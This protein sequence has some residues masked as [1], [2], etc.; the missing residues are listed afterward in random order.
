MIDVTEHYDIKFGN[1]E[2]F[3]SLIMGIMFSNHYRH[4]KSEDYVY[5]LSEYESDWRIYWYI[6]SCHIL[7]HSLSTFVQHITIYENSYTHIYWTINQTCIIRNT[8]LHDINNGLWDPWHVSLTDC[9]CNMCRIYCNSED[10]NAPITGC[11]CKTL[12]R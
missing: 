6:T 5:D 2:I 4:K 11:G 1:I 12:I 8:Y 3:T 7:I 10:K 9:A